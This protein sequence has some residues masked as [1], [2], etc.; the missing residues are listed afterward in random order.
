MAIGIFRSSALELVVTDGLDIG[1]SVALTGEAISVGSASSNDLVLTEPL[2]EPH[3]LRL[4]RT[5]NRWQLSTVH[6]EQTQVD[7]QKVRSANL[8]EKSRIVLSDRVALRLRRI[9]TVEEKEKAKSEDNEEPTEGVKKKTLQYV[10]LGLVGIVALVGFAIAPDPD[11][12][13]RSS[14]SSQKRLPIIP[15]G[16]LQ[17]CLARAELA[18]ANTTVTSGSDLSAQYFAIARLNARTE[19][20]IDMR[21][22]LTGNLIA[23]TERRLAQ[24]MLLTRRGLNERALSEYQEILEMVPDPSCNFV[25]SVSKRLANLSRN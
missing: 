4:M 5:G 18:S 24:A 12:L 1:R 25:V 10:I 19:Q 8:G 9:V 6:R 2:I 22:A 16:D 20:D 13:R 17:E 3:H 11:D 23:A 14:V 15:V 21:E 7:G